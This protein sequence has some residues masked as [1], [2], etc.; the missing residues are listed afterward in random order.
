MKNKIFIIVIIILSLSV[1]AIAYAQ[2]GQTENDTPTIDKRQ[3]TNRSPKPRRGRPP[4]LNLA[5]KTFRAKMMVE[6]PDGIKAVRIDR[7]KVVS[8]SNFEIDIEESDGRIVTIKFDE[9]TKFAGKKAEE[10]GEGDRVQ[11]IREKAEGEEYKTRAIITLRVSGDR[12]GPNGSG[13]QGDRLP[14][15]SRD[16]RSNK[17]GIF[18]R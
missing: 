14:L 13:G 1:A 18:H 17:N 3:K 12:K 5:R 10:L 11:S 7:G 15:R 6:T 16:S 9:D 2:E 4:L 8:I